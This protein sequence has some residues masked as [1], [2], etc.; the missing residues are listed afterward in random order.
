MSPLQM[1]WLAVT[2]ATIV[3]LIVAAISALPKMKAAY[4]ASIAAIFL[5][6]SG[7]TAF[8]GIVPILSHVGLAPPAAALGL[9]PPAAPPRCPARRWPMTPP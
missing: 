9:V 5:A 4:T 8:G 1:C 6:S 7:I 2:G 3:F